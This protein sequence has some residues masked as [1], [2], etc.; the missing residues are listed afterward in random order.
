M[1]DAP[2]PLD[3]GFEQRTLGTILRLQAQRLPDRTWL[4]CGEDTWSFAQAD[5]E[6]DRHA[7]GLAALGVGPGSA[8]AVMLTASPTYL[9]CAL[10][11]AR[12]GAVFVPINLELSGAALA[13]P[14]RVAG[15]GWIIVAGELRGRAAEAAGRLAEPPAILDARE[16][17]AAPTPQ[18]LPASL[19]S[20]TDPWSI[21]FTSGTTGAAK[22][23]LMTHQYWWLVPADLCG[24][25]RAV[26]HDDVFYSPLPMYHAAAWL[27]EILPALYLGM[28]VGVD[29]GFSVTGF[30]DRVRHYGATQLTTV[31]ATHL[32]LY[33]YPARADDR[34]TPARVWA[35]VP[36][37]A[38]LWAPFRERFG[39]EHL[40]STYGGTEFM[41]VAFTDLR[42]AIKPGSAG[43]ARGSVELS[44]LDDLGRTLAP[45]QVGELCVRPTA[46]HAIFRGYVGM[47]ETT[48]ARCADLWYHTG[49]LGRI[50][51]DGD[52]FF[53]DRKDDYLRVRGENVSSFEV[54]SA[55]GEHPAVLEVAAHGVRTGEAELVLEDEIKVC[56]VLGDGAVVSEAD[57]VAFARERLPRFALPRY[58][59]LVAD[60]PRSATGR[61]RKH[62]LRAQGVTAGTWER[63]GR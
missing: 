31:A 32:W 33:Q 62:V 15:A 60:L 30:L 19:A 40:W 17:R 24:P 61:V 22:G 10:A 55:L 52:V 43:Q 63:P 3:P 38:E 25:A 8:V 12:L 26:R 9:F 28:P 57:L 4:M 1:S 35:P 27:M 56:V 6:V 11:L 44:V 5:R 37:P 51:E 48:L 45:G 46:P 36:L 49:D 39:L 59:E 50:D 20:T 54:E 41:N 42:R 18:P 58:V 23:A 13:H 29:A 53:L 47:P 34:D 21:M 7:S 14:L 2:K 16:V